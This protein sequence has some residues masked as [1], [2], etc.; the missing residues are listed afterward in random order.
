MG[1]A[2]LLARCEPFAGLDAPAMAALAATV[3]TVSLRRNQ[4]LFAEGEAATELFVVRRGRV[5]VAK[6]GAGGRQSVVALLGAGDVV[7]EMGLFDGAGRSADARA[8]DTA[9][10][11]AVPYAAAREV[12]MAHP[13]SLW[14][15][16]ALLGRRLRATDETLAD[17]VFLDVPARTA[18]RLLEVAGDGGSFS[19]AL[20]QEELAS[21]VGASRERVNKAIAT[22]VRLGWVE[23][24][25]RRY[26]VVDPARLAAC[27]E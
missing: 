1:D 27:A 15:L 18:K 7:G 12:L 26:R 22:F 11:V 20:T 14:T 9:E 6:R 8:I 19:A 25:G 21:M 10:V 5:A 17:T 2:E 4:L 16:V 23:Q 13:A 24:S 3:R